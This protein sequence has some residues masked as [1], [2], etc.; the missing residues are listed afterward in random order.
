MSRQ[1]RRQQQ[2][3]QGVIARTGGVSLFSPCVYLNRGKYVLVEL[4]I[5]SGNTASVG[6]LLIDLILS[7][8]FVVVAAIRLP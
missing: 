2:I 1:Q 3:V 6:E 7:L 5:L 4:N 8:N